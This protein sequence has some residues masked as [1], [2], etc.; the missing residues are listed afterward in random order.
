MRRL[1]PLIVLAVAAVSFLAFRPATTTDAG[2]LEGVW[3]TVHVTLTNDEGTEEF[4]S[5]A[6]NLTIYTATHYATVF[7]VGE[8]PRE[9]LPEDPTDAQLLAAW[10]RFRATAGTYEVKGNEIHNKV[11][12]SKNPNWRENTAT[13][14]VDG[15]TMVYTF[16]TDAGLT[17]KVRYTRVE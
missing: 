1:T 5:P 7:V 8:E 17:V 2:D 15:D 16:T 11:I 3:K 10:R 12:V 4:D 14:E 6:P 13:L 9:A